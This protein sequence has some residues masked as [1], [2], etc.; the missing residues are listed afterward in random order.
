MSPRLRLP[1][2]RALLLQALPLPLA[3][4]PQGDR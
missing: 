4:P 1:A 3:A 2:R